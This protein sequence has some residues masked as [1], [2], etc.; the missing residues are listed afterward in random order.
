MKDAT[1]YAI[2]GGGRAGLGMARAMARAGC[3]VTAVVARRPAG[4]ALA[5]RLLRR[6]VG[7][8]DLAGAV[9]GAGVV[10]ICVG[11]DRIPD[12]VEA[13]RLL[14]L[15]GKQVLHTSGALPAGALAPLGRA[16]A[17][18]GSLHPL[19]SFPVPKPGTPAI[20][21]HGVAF[22]VDG[23]PAAARAARAIARAVGG[24][25]VTVPAASRGAYH[26]AASI[27]ANDLVALLDVGLDLAARSMKLPRRR[28]RQA[29][30]PLVRACVENVSRTGTTA[31]LTGPVARGDFRTVSR[32]LSI[33][34]REEPDLER[35]HRLLS[36]RAVDMARAR[37][38]L[39]AA[40]AR[41]LRRLLGC[42][43]PRRAGRGSGS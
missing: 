11:D 1:R 16:G 34:S 25:P 17:R 39:S 33:L 6:R 42:G 41:E 38:D 26:L 20:D 36:C 22:A 31:A 24:H 27:L 4:A 7:T 15:S 2:V 28:V 40:R 21:L 30:L 14:P 43:R 9:S 23:D 12:V 18:I 10:L 37:G 32:H 19:A 29:L 5:T 8:T 13:M 3:A 35:L